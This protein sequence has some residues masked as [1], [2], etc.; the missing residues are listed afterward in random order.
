MIDR[1]NFCG[2][3]VLLVGGL[4]TTGCSSS[5]SSE[6]AAAGT[7]AQTPTC[8]V[9]DAG[10]A[11]TLASSAFAECTTIPADYTCGGGPGARPS[12]PLSWTAGPAE[13][14]G[15][16]IVLKDE[17][18]G[19]THWA[20][21]DIPPTVTDLA[22]D[23]PQTSHALTSPPGAMQVGGNTESLGYI[24]PCP[25]SGPH[26]YVFTVY[27]QSAL[28]LANVT[29]SEYADAVAVEIGA[30][31]LAKGTLGAIVTR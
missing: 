14:K 3:C 17:T 5:D 27:A 18:I 20:L 11:M 7:P 8:T 26:R 23:V 4:V 16:A 15:Y 22:A 6:G 29:T 28:P 31:S 24:R 1:L 9:S 12:P 19:F 25:P 30:Q 21:W 2:S 10:G 13:T